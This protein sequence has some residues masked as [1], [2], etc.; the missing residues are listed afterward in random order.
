MKQAD[1]PHRRAAALK[2]KDAGDWL[3]HMLVLI[4]NQARRDVAGIPS[5]PK[6]AIHSLRKRMK[7]ARSL[8]LLA[9]PALDDAS[10][11][12]IKAG[13]REI[14]DAA[15]SQ[16][17]TD[18]MAGLAEDLGVKFPGW[19]PIPPDITMLDAYVSELAA[20]FEEMDLHGLTWNGITV[21]HLKTCRRTREAWKKA[22]RQP[23]E[24]RLHTW[25]KRVKQ[26]YH[27]SLALH[28]WL[29]QDGRLRRMRR[30]GSVLGHCH[31]L[32]VFTS[33]VTPD[34]KL[35][36]K[37][38]NRQRKLK[39]RAFRRAEKIFSRPLS[40]TRNRVRTRLGPARQAA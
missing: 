7:K 2:I 39:Q 34:K 9:G 8:L 22:Q 33:C 28:R 21:C 17:D 14:K 29:G 13:I 5:R 1:T 18:V 35:D 6:S 26:Q 36:R 19:R 4:A 12:T 30:L 27:Q 23:S 11:E 3:Q 40:K 20:R 24:K 32:D 16:R 15:M 38:G 31:D 25:R 10:L 37:V